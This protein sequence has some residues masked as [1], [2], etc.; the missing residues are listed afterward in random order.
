MSLLHIFLIGTGGF[1]GACSR[2]FISSV[3]VRRCSTKFPYGTLTVNLIGSFF[4]GLVI[5]CLDSS[6]H[7]FMLFFATGFLGSFT[8]FSTF[9]VEIQKMF[10]N[11]YWKALLL[12][13]ICSYVFGILL[14]YIGFLIGLK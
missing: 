14:A 11:K 2:F 12:Y 1:L 7:F 5:G 8:T 3:F 13:I 9:K 10:I 6:Y 4:L